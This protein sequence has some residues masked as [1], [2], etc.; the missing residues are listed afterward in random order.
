M[1]VLDMILIYL[2]FV[3]KTNTLII[4][5]TNVCTVYLA[6]EKLTWLSSHHLLYLLL[7]NSI[8]YRVL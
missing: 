1:F 7:R 3:A 5:P 4:S 8:L 2:F 6:W